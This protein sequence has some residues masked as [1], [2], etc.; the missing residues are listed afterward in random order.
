MCLAG[1]LHSQQVEESDDSPLIG[2]LCSIFGPP[3]Q[4]KDQQIGPGRAE[5][6]RH[7]KRL[8]EAGF[9]WPGKEDPQGNVTTVFRYLR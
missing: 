9:D 4:G 2:A 7:E 1:F 8:R 3:V 5:S 6:T